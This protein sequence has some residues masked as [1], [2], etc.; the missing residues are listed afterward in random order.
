MDIQIKDNKIFAPLKDKWLINKPEEH[1]RQ[2]YICRLVDSYGYSL[3]QMAQEMQVNNAQRGQG[4]AR[5]DIVIWRSKEEKAK[6]KTA[7][8]VVECKAESVTIHEEDYFQGYNYASWMGADFF[9]TT[10]NKETRVFRVVKGEPSKRLEEIA[11]IPIAEKATNQKEID[12]LL[13][14]TKA[15]TREEFSKLLF[16]CHNIIRN[17]DKL[18]PEA[19][20]DEISKI[21]FIKIRYERRNSDTQIFS[22]EKFRQDRESYNLCKFKGAPEFYQVLF[23][24]TKHDYV[25]DRLFDP[26][27]VIKIRENSFE[28]IIKELEIYNLSTTSDDVKGIAFEKVLG[29]TFRGELGQFFTP[30]TVVD[31]MVKVLDPQEGEYICDPCCGSGGFLIDA[32]EYVR[33]KIEKD[34]EQQK[35]TIKKQFYTDAY[36]A[37]PEKEKEVIDAKVSYAFGVLNHELDINNT[38][39]RLRS[40]SFDCIYGTDANPRMARTAKMN[41]IMHGDGHGGVHHHDGLLNVNGIFENRFDII[42]TNPPFG[43]HVDKSLLISEADKFAD[44]EKIDA[45]VKRY[46]QAYLEALKQVNDH[47]GEPLL[48]LYETGKMSGLTEVLFIERCLNLLKPGGR[49]GIVLPEGV[50]NS[51]NLQKVRDFV[52]SKAKILLVVSIPQ[53]VF[54]ASGA[55]VKPSLLFFRKFTEEETA[56]YNAIVIAAHKE[57]EKP[58]NKELK[59]IAT[60]LAKRG[61]EASSKEEKK[62][63]QTRQKEIRVAIETETKKLVKERFDYQIPIA[64]VQKA[65]ISTTGAPI[66]NELEPLEQEFSTYRKKNNLWNVLLN[67]TIYTVSEDGKVSRARLEFRPQCGRN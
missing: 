16:K 65:G 22:H 46:G 30:R 42:L 19:A 18:S 7:L 35:E 15:F 9:V 28:Q 39:G 38:D 59:D 27:D 41:M 40:L 45:Y 61:K 5:A 43:A 56:Q 64:E 57:A 62:Q 63:L 10:N 51:T 13:K 26:N 2:K 20:F 48:N 55:T 29:R 12:K 53:D 4:A 60:K 23:E 47:I 31:F 8:I 44:R 33:T 52:E 49:M 11:D 34:I 36:D 1:V 37:L 3:D 54:I 58:Y 21:L 32:F 25:N 66:E 6:D 24:Q 67:K 14:Q 50:L 17:N